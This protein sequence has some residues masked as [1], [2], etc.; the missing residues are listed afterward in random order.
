MESSSLGK[1]LKKILIIGAGWSG[2]SAATEATKRGLQ[3]TLVEAKKELGGRARSVTL[4]GLTLDNGQHILIGAYRATL[5]LISSVGLQPESLLFRQTLSLKNK[6][7]IG[8]SLVGSQW[9]SPSMRFLIGTLKSTNWSLKDRYTLISLAATWSL[10]HF[11]CEA[12]K[13]V[14]DLCEGLSDQVIDSFITPL[15]LSAFNS[16]IG[17]TSGQVFLRVLQDALL[18]GSGSSDFLIPRCDLD[19]LFP[20][21]CEK[22]LVQQGCIIKKGVRIENLQ[23][24]QAQFGAI[25]VACDP[26]NAARLIDGVNPKWSE[27]TRQLEHTQI[28]TTYIRCKDT[29]YKGLHK[30][31]LM[32]ASD[33]GNSGQVNSPAQFVFDRG[34]LFKDNPDSLQ[35]R[36]NQGILSFVSS[37]ATLTNSQITLAVL[38]QARKELGLSDLEVLG[39]ILERRAAFCCKPGLTRPANLASE[40]VWVCG[41]YVKG[42]YP[43][44]L[45]GAVLSGQEVV[46][47]LINSLR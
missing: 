31:L 9:L 4:N 35:A 32:L 7:D 36:A 44:T 25:I 11:T 28:A 8:F 1:I 30:P 47:N 39:T 40:K 46:G 43:S 26:T 17:M 2:L 22:W 5:D 14:Q 45:E 38:D 24:L 37:Y 21:A 27:V 15:C 18:S 13:S 41:D 6:E 23:D 33:A 42:P 19:A 34:Y 3:V 29:G 16:P 12:N 20:Q 10:N